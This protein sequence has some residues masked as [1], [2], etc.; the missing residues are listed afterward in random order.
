[1]QPICMILVGLPGFVSAD[2]P[3]CLRHPAEIRGNDFSARHSVKVIRPLLHHDFTLIQEFRVIVCA[4]HL[5]LLTV[6]Q[7]T[8][9][10]SC[11]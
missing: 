2:R 6:R 11:R 4:R 9:N 5:G 8:V 10:S 1:M 3:S 7:L